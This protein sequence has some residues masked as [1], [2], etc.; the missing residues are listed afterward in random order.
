MELILQ[1]EIKAVLL[2]CYSTIRFAVLYVE[3]TNW[4][5]KV[6]FL[7]KISFLL[8]SLL[9]CNILT[10]LINADFILHLLTDQLFFSWAIKFLEALMPQDIS[11]FSVNLSILNLSSFSRAEI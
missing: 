9:P 5:F 10:E 8:Y 3:H 1:V 6:S 11:C 7:H 2:L 4:V